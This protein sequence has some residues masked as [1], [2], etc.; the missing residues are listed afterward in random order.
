MKTLAN[1]ALLALIVVTGLGSPATADHAAKVPTAN[2]AA[3]IE[4]RMPAR[5]HFLILS[6]LEAD[7]LS[8]EELKAT[9]GTGGGD[10]RTSTRPPTDF[11]TTNV[12]E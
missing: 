6:D 1:S 9:R 4:A 10:G 12:Q 5:G 8:E 3:T 7:R 11:T 2:E